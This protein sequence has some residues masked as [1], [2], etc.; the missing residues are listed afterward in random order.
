MIEVAYE[1]EESP[2]DSTFSAY[3]ETHR[4]AGLFIR[5]LREEGIDF[6]I[7]LYSEGPA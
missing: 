5:R 6:E 2:F 3:F 4:G 7:D 1:N